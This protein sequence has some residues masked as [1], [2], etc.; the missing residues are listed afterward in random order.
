VPLFY[1]HRTPELQL[2]NPDLNED[3][4]N[5]IEA[6]ELDPEQES[7]LERELSRQYHI[8]IGSRMPTGAA[9]CAHRVCRPRWRAWRKWFR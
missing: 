1:E 5:L 2:M 8:L 9:R 7:K 3:I 4:Y 6:A